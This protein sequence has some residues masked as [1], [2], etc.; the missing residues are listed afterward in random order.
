MSKPLRIIG[1]VTLLFVLMF[2]TFTVAPQSQIVEAN[3]STNVQ[4]SSCSSWE[5]YK[6]TY[7]CVH[8]NQTIV[9]YYERRYCPGKGWETRVR[10]KTINGC[11]N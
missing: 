5:T 9:T 3:T 1:S 8:R 4:P 10:T 11:M 6:T 7:K 2:G